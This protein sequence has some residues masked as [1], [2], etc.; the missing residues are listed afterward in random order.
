MWDGLIGWLPKGLPAADDRGWVFGW[1]WEMGIMA[2]GGGPGCEISAV[3][4]FGEN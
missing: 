2:E 1:R 3:Q 4:A